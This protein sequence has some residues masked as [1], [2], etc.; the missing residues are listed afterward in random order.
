MNVVAVRTG[1]DRVLAGD[2]ADLSGVSCGL[3]AHPASVTS[4]LTF[5]ADALLAAGFD[6]RALFGPQHGAR[7][8]KQDNMIESEYYAD[9]VTGLPVHSLY[10]DVRKPTPEMLEGIDVV[11]KALS[12]ETFSHEGPKLSIPPRRLSPR[13]VQVPHPP[14]YAA[15][16]SMEM[17]EICGQKGIG[18]MFGDTGLGWEYMTE[19]FE[20][21]RKGIAQ[22]H[23][24]SGHLNDS[25]GFISFSVC[26]RKTREEAKAVGGNDALQFLRGV[27]HV[28]TELSKKSDDY[29]YMAEIKRLKQYGKDLDYLMEATPSILLG[30]PDDLIE[31]CK[32]LE[33]Q[34]VQE[35]IWRIENEEHEETLK[36]LDLIGRYVIPEFKTP[37]AVTRDTG[38]LPGTVP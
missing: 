17:A 28:Y 16:T 38:V 19:G 2:C 18:L 29:A 25:M 12:Q 37:G 22:T 8:E 23:P 34:G 7:G 31:R 9:P 26:C 3:I 32:M 36:S 20:S 21:Y 6:L 14:F 5:S 33:K 27:S 11:A 1:I 30:S 24:V 13:A 10:G 35:V 4:N 15:C